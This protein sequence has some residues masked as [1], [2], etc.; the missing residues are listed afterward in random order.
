M[1]CKDYA[2]CNESKH[3]TDSARRSDHTQRVFSTAC[4]N[5]RLA[6]ASACILTIPPRLHIFSHTTSTKQCMCPSQQSIACHHAAQ[7]KTRFE[8][9]LASRS[10]ENA[11]CSAKPNGMRLKKTPGSGYS[12]HV[13]CY[14]AFASVHTECLPVYGSCG[15]ACQL[16]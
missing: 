8:R 13:A 5:S 7:R 1:L 10:T 3:Y 4:R 6:A 16:A 12:G 9:T 2:E 11:T 14:M 15:S